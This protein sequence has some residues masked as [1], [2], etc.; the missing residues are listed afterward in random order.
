MMRG[1]V[2]RVQIINESNRQ[3][4]FDISYEPR[5]AD[6]GFQVNRHREGVP[7]LATVGAVGAGAKRTVKVGHNPYITITSVRYGVTLVHVQNEHLGGGIRITKRFTQEEL[8]VY[9]F[10]RIQMII[11]IVFVLVCV[12]ICYRNG[13]YGKIFS[14]QGLV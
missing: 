3:I 6:I 14:P 9:R 12:V 13:I 7:R 10:E 1:Q 8:G 4:K 11:M 2:R 5:P